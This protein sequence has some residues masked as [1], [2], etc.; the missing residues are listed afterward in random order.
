MPSLR[1]FFPLWRAGAGY[2]WI[3]FATHAPTLVMPIMVAAQLG[4]QANAGFYAALCLVGVIWI[5]PTHLATAM[6]TLDH[7]NAEHFGPGLSTA[8]R[9][10]GVVSILAAAGT[11]VLARPVLAIFGSGYEQARYCLIALGACTFAVAIKYIY[12]PVRR[13]QGALGKAALAITL[14]TV[15]ELGAAELGLKLGAVT[16]VGIAYGVAT[17]LEALCFWPAI[18][19]A[20][21]SSIRQATGAEHDLRG[22]EREIPDIDRSVIER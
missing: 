12:I 9:L 5:I 11:A 3:N 22:Q 17:L 6:L 20:R 1:G 19:K 15:L 4:A 8:L 13:A 14:G 10:S 18:R 21:K 16:G 2:H 7:G